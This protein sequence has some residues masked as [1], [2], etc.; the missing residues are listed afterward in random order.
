MEVVCWST[1]SYLVPTLLAIRRRVL[2][3]LPATGCI[4]VLAIARLLIV[5]LILISLSISSVV[6]LAPAA[7]VASASA[8]S[9]S[10]SYAGGCIRNMSYLVPIYG[11]FPSR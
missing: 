1:T 7:V 9:A 5:I 11:V 10:A 3:A 2:L 8:A 4:I 6:A